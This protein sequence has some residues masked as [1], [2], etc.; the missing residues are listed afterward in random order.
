MTGARDLPVCASPE[1]LAY[2]Y[3]EYE[4]DEPVCPE[5]R[6]D[7]TDRYTDHLLPCPL[8]QGEQTP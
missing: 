7:G 1:E 2:L 4:D 5:C 3:P 6:G 8:C